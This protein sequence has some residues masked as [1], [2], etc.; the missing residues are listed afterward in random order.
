M[1]HYTIFNDDVDIDIITKLY[2]DDKLTLTEI[3]KIYN[4]NASV[5]SKYMDRNNIN[6][7]TISE[8]NTLDVNE[9]L[10]IDLYND[11]YSTIDIKNKLNISINKIISILSNNN[12]KI[13]NRSEA[14]K[15]NKWQKQRREIYLSKEE[16]INLYINKNYSSLEIAELFNTNNWNILNLLHFYNIPVRSLEDI[17]NNK[18]FQTKLKNINQ[19]LYGVDYYMQTNEFSKKAK[20]TYKLKYNVDNPFKL[21][22]FQEKAKNMMYQNGTVSTSKQ[23]IYLCNLLNGELNYPISKLN[24]DI[25]FLNEKIYLEYHGGG[26]NLNVK[27][28]KI[29][30]KE[31]NRKEQKREMFLKSKGWSEIKI[32]S[33]FDRLPSD[34]VILQMIEYAKEY[35]N[36]GHS[37]IKFDIDNLKIIK[38]T[39][40]IKVDFGDLRK[41]TK[42]DLEEV[43]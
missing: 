41:I 11:E 2:R 20:E 12:I 27:L 1:K 16:L 22:Y 35:L 8:A 26:H 40:N 23:Q 21:D 31:F 24:L 7:R 4:T 34:E 19:N 3:S 38:S 36:E 30:E 28:G 18:D 10:I 43:S 39:G 13:R 17:F 9:Q 5:I 25:V 15:S 32:V 33:R 6:K 14:T 29:T 37:W 42:S